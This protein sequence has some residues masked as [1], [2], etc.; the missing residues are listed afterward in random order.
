MIGE[1]IGSYRILHKLG[2]GGMGAV[3]VA[4]HTLLGR[5][6]AIKVLL[7]AL[8]S[9]PEVVE[10]F[11]NEARAVTS[12]NDPGIVQVFDFG[13]HRDGSA[14]IVMELLEG[15][16]LNARMAQRG[17]LSAV[18]ALRIGRQVAVSLA[19]VHHH[20]IVH[21]DLKP[22]NVFMVRDPEVAHGERAKILDFGIAKLS[23]DPSMSKTSA[24]A[25]LGTPMYM[26]PEQCRGAGEVDF[27]SDI[28]A[29]G[30]MLFHLAVGQPPFVGSGVGDV[31]VAH[32]TEPAPAPSSRCPGLPAAFDALVLRCLAKSPDERFA[33]MG[34]V[35]HAID[36][37]LP[38]LVTA[39]LPTR[40]MVGAGATPPALAPMLTPSRSGQL[41]QW[42][43]S[44]SGVAPG[45]HPGTAPGSHAGLAGSHAGVSPG[46][47]PGTVA[48]NLPTTLGL[49][50]RAAMEPRA[51]SAPRVMRWLGALGALSLAATVVL[52]VSLRGGAREGAPA[53]DGLTSAAQPGPSEVPATAATTPEHAA[54]APAAEHD[55]SETAPSA[56]V[57]TAPA[58]D[59]AATAT[60]NTTT[61]GADHAAAAQTSATEA[62]PA[63]EPPP[64][65][66]A[67][68]AMDGRDAA[69]AS[70]TKD[71]DEERRK[72]RRRSRKDRDGCDRA[73]DTDC[74]GIP[75]V[76]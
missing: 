12:I 32:M 70:S 60:S 71:K 65:T 37:V 62:T 36:G 11:F 20:G 13:H 43:A 42:S 56:A 4:Q 33:H 30:C 39:E 38:N 9:Q 50:A 34:E 54:G 51:A 14:F 67:A 45:A 26:S 41:P 8:S 47:H 52:V 17:R 21:R 40:M 48:L 28:Y 64:A 68:G 72:R 57:E 58:A 15:E 18:E 24:G 49:S 75:D 55:G 1:T 22:E 16:A 5:K 25:L 73:I 59:H 61:S 66:Q 53:D 23:A 29:L 2:E 35:A 31:L 46:S 44:S 19:T 74:D 27:R 69:D 3:Y 10:R 76:R 7:P 63:V 6:A